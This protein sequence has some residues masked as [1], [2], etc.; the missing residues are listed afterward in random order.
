MG[1]IIYHMGVE[2]WRNEFMKQEGIPFFVWY[3]VFSS[4][5][6]LYEREVIKHVD[7]LKS[8]VEPIPEKKGWFPWSK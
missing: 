7:A 8:G 2:R 4:G 5:L 6:K 3:L 1:S